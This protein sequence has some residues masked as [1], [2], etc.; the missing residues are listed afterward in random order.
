[1]VMTDKAG[2]TTEK[3]PLS[4]TQPGATKDSV[5]TAI[6]SAISKYGPGV[7]LAVCVIVILS[8]GAAYW[9]QRNRNMAGQ[10]WNTVTS[11][12][13]DR[14]VKGLMEAAEAA[15]DSKAGTVAVLNAGAVELNS[16]L[17]KL[18]KDKVKAKEEINSAIEKLKQARDSKFSEGLMKDQ[19]TYSLAFA[20]ESLGQFEEAKPLY[21]ELVANEESQFHSLAQLGAS[22]CDN[23]ET[24]AL[25]DAFSKWE[26]AAAGSA[27]D[28]LSELL[29]NGPLDLS[30]P[31]ELNLDG[32]KTEGD[33]DDL[34]GLPDLGAPGEG[35]ATDDES[36]ESSETT[37]EEAGTTTE[38][39]DEAEAAKTEGGE[40]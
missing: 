19:A 26:P 14:N 38:K 1:M 15:R 20:Y 25:F 28:D 31:E 21:E 10:T 7:A 23:P 11:A 27:P 40:G 39:D 4:N 37:T 13:Q 24:L 6:E 12:F 35:G 17:E 29:K 22:R 32:D 16:G 5:E 9:I 34:P 18:L 30:P 36:T 33:S 2:E 3:V 8:A